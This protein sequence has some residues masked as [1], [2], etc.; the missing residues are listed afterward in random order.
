MSKCSNVL[1]VRLNNVADVFIKMT[2]S[3]PKSYTEHCQWLRN[4]TTTPPTAIPEAS[5]NLWN[6]C[7]LLRAK[8]SVFVVLSRSP[9][10]RWH[11][12]T[13]SAHSQ[14]LCVNSESALI[15]VYICVSSDCWWCET[16]NPSIILP[17]VMVKI[18]KRNDQNTEPCGTT[19]ALN[20]IVD[21]RPP[22]GTLS[23]YAWF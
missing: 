15:A 9:F 1:A 10:S 11:L 4:G 13:A 20:T 18:E 3:H 14:R 12:V 23:S 7:L 22:T 16:P 8:A 2:N 6:C 17:S 19:D 5:S 21:W